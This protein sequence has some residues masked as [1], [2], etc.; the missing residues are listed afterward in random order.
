[1]ALE[2]TLATAD[3]ARVGRLVAQQGGWVA[4]GLL[5]YVV[6]VGFDALGWRTFLRAGGVR[7]ARA[8]WLA[9]TRLRIDSFGATLPGG[10]LVAESIAP[11]WLRR[12][13]PLEAAVA[14]IAARKCFVGLAEAAYVF[15]SF[16][17]GFRLLQARAAVLPWVVFGGAVALLGLFG[18]TT[19]ALA[20][21]ATAARVH[22][23][24]ASLPIPALRRWLD[25][26][27]HG[28]SSTD[29]RLAALFRSEPRRLWGAGALFVASWCMESFETWLL[30]RLVGVALP[31]PTVFAFEASVSLLRS[32]ACFA[33]G[34][35]GVQDLGYVATLG[36]LGV[37]D[38]VN[39]GAAFVLLKRAKD[40]F[41]AAIGYATL[42]HRA[43]RPK[44]A[45][46]ARMEAPA[47]E[48]TW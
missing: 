10:T 26:R 15:A 45:R 34:G 30:L 29:E 8:W 42:Y 38:A 2:R 35:L 19:V 1:V 36:A 14:A 43:Q 12:W 46:P 7:E 17:V 28:F 16:A 13:I 33:P 18:G 48:A 24:L 32:L 22:A 27:A 4:L 9:R 23:W 25:A 39:A 40:L 3:F 44:A 31:F 5:P 41:W 47:P 11:T 6:A 21:G 20:S 37:P